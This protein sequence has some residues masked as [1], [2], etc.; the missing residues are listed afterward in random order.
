MDEE[1]LHEY[2]TEAKRDA[3]SLFSKKAVGNVADEYVK[4][5][6]EK[7]KSVYNQIKDENERESNQAC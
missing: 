7:M 4:E 5:L 3:L 6:K 1:E 2:Y